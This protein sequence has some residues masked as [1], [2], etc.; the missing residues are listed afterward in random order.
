MFERLK[1]L[2]RATLTVNIE[3]PAAPW[4]GSDCPHLVPLP[5]PDDPSGE[6]RGK[7]GIDV[8]ICSR[9]PSCLCFVS[10]SEPVMPIRYG[11]GVTPASS[12]E[13]V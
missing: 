3:K 12:S 1:W 4:I 13:D 10:G 8:A 9:D 5:S 2:L 7:D 11:T 6:T